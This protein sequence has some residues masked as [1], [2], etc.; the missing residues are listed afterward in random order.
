MLM[1]DDMGRAS[2]SEAIMGQLALLSASCCHRICRWRACAEEQHLLYTEKPV[3]CRFQAVCAQLQPCVDVLAYKIEHAQLYASACSMLKSEKQSNST[4]RRGR[5]HLVC[6]AHK[7]EA[8]AVA[9]VLCAV[10]KP[11]LRVRRDDRDHAQVANHLPHE[12]TRWV[13][14][15]A[16]CKCRVHCQN[17]L[18]ACAMR[19][20]ASACT[21]TMH[22]HV[23]PWE[24]ASNISRTMHSH[25]MHASSR[26]HEK[27]RALAR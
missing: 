8:H 6:A 18:Q 26:G 25:Q 7:R 20:Y 21:S 24:G 1:S 5:R 27:A 11:E 13:T 2:V 23:W 10:R 9:L 16:L 3:C 22:W 12:R 14:C 15:S 4:H 19:C 17:C